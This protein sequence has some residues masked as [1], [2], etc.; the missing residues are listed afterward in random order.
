MIAP[1]KTFKDTKEAERHNA[2]TGRRG[3][4]EWKSILNLNLTDTNNNNNELTHQ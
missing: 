4:S 1:H 2:T 3:R